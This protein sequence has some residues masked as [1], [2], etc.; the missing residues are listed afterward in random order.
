MVC[1]KDKHEQYN[2]KNSHHTKV[3]KID[4]S[5]TIAIITF[6]KKRSSNDPEKKDPQM[7]QKKF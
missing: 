5:V 1:L 3:L 2:L 7:I 4:H 6:Q